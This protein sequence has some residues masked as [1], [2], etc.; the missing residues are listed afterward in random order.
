M[1]LDVVLERIEASREDI[2]DLM[3]EMIAIPAIAPESG[4]EGE[5]ERADLLQRH[6]TGFDT[7]RRIDVPDEYDPSV[8]RPNIL[9][10]KEGEGKGTVWIVAHTDTVPAGD[11]EEWDTDPFEAVFK[12]GRIYGRGTEDNGQAILSSIFASRFIPSGI[13]SRRSIGIALVA[14]EETTSRMGIDHLLDHG[15]FSE[16]D[17]F[18]VPD[19]G[20]PGGSMIEIAEKNLIWLRFEVIGKATHGSTPGKGQNAFRVGTYFL[21]ELMGRFAKEFNEADPLFEPPTSTFEPT[22]NEITSLNVNTIPGRFEFY[23][24][25]RAIPRYSLDDIKGAAEALAEEYGRRTGIRIEIS[26][27]QRHMSGRMSSTESEVYKAL[28]SSVEEVVGK[29]PT[30]VGVGGATC[31]NFFRARG[32]DAYVWQHGGGTLHSPNE[33]A[34]LDNIVIDAKVFATLFYKLCV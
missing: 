25:I 3:S 6:L 11:L 20:S 21:A 14:D 30:A 34:V 32:Y 13:L 4:G 9:A 12:D 31:A 27:V 22:K 1:E 10:R 16:D 33:Y 23:M 15:C 7:I 2:V 8:M 18:I 5:S 28:S 29:K 19:W 17:V 26:E 24:D